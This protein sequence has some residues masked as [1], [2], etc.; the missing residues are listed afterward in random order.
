MPSFLTLP[1]FLKDQVSYCSRNSPALL[2]WFGLPFSVPHHGS[3]H[4]AMPGLLGVRTY[5][6]VP[7]F[8]LW[9]SQPTE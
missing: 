1:L 2:G 5:N 6:T 9:I 4:T 8:V 3:R 7:N